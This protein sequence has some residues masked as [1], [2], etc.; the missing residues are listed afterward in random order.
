MLTANSS[1]ETALEAIRLGASG[2]LLKPVEPDQIIIRVREVLR[3]AHQ[4]RR[5]REIINE[6]RGIVSELQQSEGFQ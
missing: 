5:R 6:I 4:T 1:I 3:E 2:Y